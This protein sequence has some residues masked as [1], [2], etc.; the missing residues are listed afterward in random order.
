MS[1]GLVARLVTAGILAP[2]IVLIVLYVPAQAFA[3]LIG[4][5]LLIGFWE[6]T[7]L[8]GL[9]GRPLRVLALLAQAGLMTALWWQLPA[10]Q[11]YLVTTI[12]CV[13]WLLALLWLRNPAFAAA[14]RPAARLL[15]WLAGVI[16][17]TGAWAAA[18]SIR[19]GLPQGTAWLLACLVV[20]Y[21]SDT[22]AFFTG[23]HFGGR[24]MAPRISPGKT[25]AGLYGAVAGSFPIA[26]ALGWLLAL[27]GPQLIGWML[28]AGAAVLMAV[29]GDLFESILKRHRQAKDSGRLFPGHGG[30]LDRSDSL[31]AAL[32]LFATGLAWLLA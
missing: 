17:I 3:A 7:R 18:V 21:G 25:W 29:A 14:D 31:L 24:K 8:A 16:A 32:P 30:L 11:L 26:L 6:W 12:A 15:K 19:D 5:L 2:A 27:R 22:L 20:I 13:F 28:L 9:P 4:G 23:R 1:S 10:A